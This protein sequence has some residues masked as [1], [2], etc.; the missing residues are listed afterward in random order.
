MSSLIREFLVTNIAG[1]VYTLYHEDLKFNVILLSTQFDSI[2]N[3]IV[4]GNHV[5]L[6]WDDGQSEN[7]LDISFDYMNKVV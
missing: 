4:A 6:C 5:E 7:W 2:E 3:G 1:T